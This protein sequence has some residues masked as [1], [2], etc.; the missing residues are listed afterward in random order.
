MTDLPIVA[1][2][3]A[4][5][6]GCTLPPKNDCNTIGDCLDGETCLGGHC[7]TPND[8]SPILGDWFLGL[9][10]ASMLDNDGVHFDAD[11]TWTWIKAIEM[12]PEDNSRLDPD[13]SYCLLPSSGTGPYEFVSGA[14]TGTS[15]DNGQVVSV[16][17]DTMELDH[18][19]TTVQ[20]FRIDPPRL[21]LTCD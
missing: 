4:L 17:L 3:V 13:E 6:S 21:K 16:V 2:L 5:A 7:I 11:G 8:K 15:P 18:E 19:G 1:C 9:P 12:P 10:D 20:L 14:L